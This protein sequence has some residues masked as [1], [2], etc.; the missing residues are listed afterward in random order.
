MCRKCFS[1]ASAFARGT[2]SF[3]FVRHSLRIAMNERTYLIQY[4]DQLLAFGF[5]PPDFFLQYPTS[6][7]FG[8]SRVEHK[9]DHISL[10]DN[11]MQRANV[12]PP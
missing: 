3:L 10:L 4:E 5:P 1:H 2:R 11:L 8:I 9:H 6:T 12:V 7:P